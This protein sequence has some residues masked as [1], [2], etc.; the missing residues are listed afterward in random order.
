MIRVPTVQSILAYFDK[1]KS[2]TAIV[3][4]CGL[5][6]GMFVYP[7]I[8]RVLD[9]KYGWRGAILLIGG[10][11]LH[12]IP[13]SALLRQFTPSSNT[14]NKPMSFCQRNFNFHLL[15]KRGYMFCIISEGLVAMGN[16]II[17]VHLSAYAVTLGVTVDQGALLFSI[18]GICG[19]IGSVT[20]ATI[21]QKGYISAIGLFCIGISL[22]GLVTI[23]CPLLETFSQL[24]IFST[25]FGLLFSSYNI[26][27]VVISELVAAHEVGSA[28]GY[29]LLMAAIGF[30]SGGPLAGKENYPDSF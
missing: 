20:I 8:I 4:T 11:T 7:P 2:I 22:T 9:D 25:L 26:Q 16:S 6:V 10:A 17:N 5:S 28:F 18:I 24:V 29:L 1:Y 19:F 12:L 14:V 13:A 21:A 15:K 27:P 23:L 3:S 30:I